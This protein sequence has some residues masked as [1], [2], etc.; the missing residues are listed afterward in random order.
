MSTE[1]LSETRRFFARIAAVGLTGA[2][3]SSGSSAQGK[4]SATRNRVVLQ[5]SDADPSKWNLALNNLHN[6]Q[7]E[8]GI[9]EVDLELVAYGPGI[10]MLKGDSPVAKRIVEALGAG[11]RFVACEN[12]MRGQNLAHGDMLPDIGY[13]PSGVV[14]L[15]RKQQAGYAYLRL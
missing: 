9:A 10:G 4:S 6:F 11:I 5:M 14:E 15:M 1:P 8:L 7:G 12:S 2:L 3:A 13:V